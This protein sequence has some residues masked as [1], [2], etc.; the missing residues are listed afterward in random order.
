MK[1]R[2]ILPIYGASIYIVVSPNIYKERMKMAD[3]FGQPP[4]GNYDALHSYD[5]CGTFGLFFKSHKVNLTT[6]AHEVFHLTHGILSWSN[7]NFDMEHQEQGALL[8]GYLM[9]WVVKETKK[10]RK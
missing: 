7:A 3:I 9:S 10:Y 2:I 1:K 5:E 6:I 4:V 8:N